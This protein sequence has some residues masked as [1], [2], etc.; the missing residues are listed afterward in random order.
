MS[1]SHLKLLKHCTTSFQTRKK[2]S[3]TPA[4][5]NEAERPMSLNREAEP[6]GWKIYEKF[7]ISLNWG[8][9]LRDVFHSSRRYERRNSSSC[10]HDWWSLCQGLGGETSSE[11]IPSRSV[12]LKWKIFPFARWKLQ[13]VGSS[14]AREDE[15]WASPDTQ[16]RERKTS[17]AACS[18]RPSRVSRAARSLLHIS[19]WN[20]NFPFVPVLIGAIGERWERK[21][22]HDLHRLASELIWNERLR[23][24]QDFLSFSSIFRAIRAG[25]LFVVVVDF[26]SFS[27]R[28]DDAGASITHTFGI[29][30]YSSSRWC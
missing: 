24:L 25:G 29:F 14:F 27:S 12:S 9:S 17:T 13:A 28:V 8:S 18:I 22:P 5:I 15:I 20:Q 4:H 6:W 7:F 30:F 2:A 11:S 10:E 21:S 23:N 16:K 1:N 26:S 3:D 19:S